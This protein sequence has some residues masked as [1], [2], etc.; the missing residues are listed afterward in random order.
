MAAKKASKRT[1]SASKR[2]A[3]RAPSAAEGSE[4][5]SKGK[6]A[7]P[8]EGHGSKANFIRVHPEES[9]QEVVSR[10]KE[11][12]LDLTPEYVS[13]QRSKFRDKFLKAHPAPEAPE[14]LV[15]L[16]LQEGVK[17]TVEEILASRSKPNKPKKKAARNS[18]AG[19]ETT[20]EAQFLKLLKILGSERAEKL[21]QRYLAE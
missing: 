7:S 5:V 1:K 14:D 19:S 16:A 10:A 3:Y 13:S 12:G 18:K 8:F 11:V 4:S 2:K 20:T 9:V 6:N 21:M 15:A 17:I